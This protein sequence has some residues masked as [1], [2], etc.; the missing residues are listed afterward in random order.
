MIYPVS[1][2]CGSVLLPVYLWMFIAQLAFP[3]GNICLDYTIRGISV[4]G[5]S[6]SIFGIIGGLGYIF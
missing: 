6:T 3:S 2:F 5:I 1:I 4:L